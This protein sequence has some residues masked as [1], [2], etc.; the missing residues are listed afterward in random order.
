LSGSPFAAGVQPSAIASDPTS[1]YLYVTDFTRGD[2]L[3]YSVAA[4]LLTPLAGS[5]FPAG[6]E[7]TAIVVDPS[8][9]YA[10]VANSQDA[11][12]T[13]YSMSSGALSRLG[14]YTTGLQPVAMGIDPSTNHFLY[15]VNYLDSTVSGFELSPTAGTLLDTQYSPFA[16][17]ALPTAVAAIPHNGVGGGVQ[18]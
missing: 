7:P 10:Y 8:Y 1:K 3:A 4:G 2:V 12:V 16:S 17:N 6:D 18:K 14:T 5:P 11:T 9:S 15:T 13:A